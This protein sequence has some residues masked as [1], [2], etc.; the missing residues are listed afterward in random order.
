MMSDDLPT[1]AIRTFSEDEELIRKRRDLI[2]E[3]ALP[4]FI[5]ASFNRTS[6]RE[7]A[8]A[9]DMSI[10]SLYHYIGTKDD[11]GFLLADQ[12]RQEMLDFVGTAFDAHRPTESLRVMIERWYRLCDKLQDN[13]VFL[14]REFGNLSK[15]VQKRIVEVDERSIAL[16]EMVLASGIR[17][18]EFRI[19]DA[20]L[21]ALNIYISGNMWAFRR[22]YLRG[23][24]TLEQYIAYQTEFFMS[25]AMMQR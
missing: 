3:R 20:K 12:L 17:T 18:G 9:C 11:I 2:A 10:G 4:L 1:N 22:W 6:V 5:K 8:R 23:H 7:I 25:S 16:F 21:F 14:Y 24:Y 19:A 13:V 15:S